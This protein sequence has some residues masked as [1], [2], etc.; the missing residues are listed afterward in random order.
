MR[1]FATGVRTDLETALFDLDHGVGSA[2]RSSR[3]RRGYRER[4]S[5]DGDDVLGWALTR[6]GRCERGSPV[7][8]RT[9]RLGTQDASKLFH[10]SLAER[11]L[12]DRPASERYLGRVIALD[13]QYVRTA[14]SAERL[15]A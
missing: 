8:G 7:L 14:P 2:T 1:R 3:A 5:I 9:L 6:N 10:R 11:C 15:G 13:P 12:G 4:P